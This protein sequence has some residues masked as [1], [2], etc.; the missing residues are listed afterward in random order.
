MDQSIKADHVVLDAGVIIK[1]QVYNFHNFGVRF[2]TTHESIHEIR[3]KKCREKLSSLPF[4]LEIRTPSKVGMHV[5]S[6]FAQ[7]SGDF[8]QLSLNDIKL[9]ALTYDL[10]MLV[11][12][13]SFVASEANFTIDVS[14]QSNKDR[15]ISLVSVQGNIDET[16]EAITGEK[17]TEH[18]RRWNCSSGIKM[19]DGIVEEKRMSHCECNNK[20][21]VNGVEKDVSLFVDEDFP[22]L[23]KLVSSLPETSTAYVSQA[24]RSKN[25]SPS[26]DR[27][28]NQSTKSCAPQEEIESAKTQ[29]NVSITKNSTSIVDSSTSFSIPSHILSGGMERTDLKKEIYCKDSDYGWITS[30]NIDRC[31]AMVEV[32]PGSAENLV[33]KQLLQPGREN[34]TS[35]TVVCV[36]TD[37]TMQNVLM[38]M[39]MNVMSIDGMLIKGLRQWVL[40]CGACFRIHFKM[41]LLFCSKCGSHLMQRIASSIDEKTGNFRLHLR[42]SYLPVTKGTKYC[43]P[44]PG[45][46]GKYDG[47]LL[48]REDQLFVGIWKQ[49]VMKMKKNVKSAFGDE[50]ASSVGVHI[51]KGTRVK[52]GLGHNNP[53]AMKGREKRGKRKKT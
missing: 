41:D 4:D 39:K 20:L 3:D 14:R 50:I 47:E 48:L 25:S 29:P 9:L 5:V 26:S 28:G 37:F 24:L 33:S 1:G 36:T 22:S 40:R 13:T 6:L 19:N 2:Y 32:I 38:R 42:K 10:N 12:S 34:Y 52:I 35:P 30:S 21:S 49:K 23:E 45:K 7:K 11:D 31:K 17:I 53:N 16:M 46:Q 43:L 18:G 8:A 27:S 51:N 44:L 15:K